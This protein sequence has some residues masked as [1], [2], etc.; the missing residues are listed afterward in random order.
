MFSTRCPL[1]QLR[2][3]AVTMTIFRAPGHCRCVDRG[4]RNVLVPKSALRLMQ[5]P[6]C[7]DA[8]AALVTARVKT[9]PGP[10]KT[11]SLLSD[12]RVNTAP[13]RV[14]NAPIRVQY[15]P[16]RVHNARAHSIV[17]ITARPTR[18]QGH[19][20]RSSRTPTTT[21]TTRASLRS[22]L[23][24]GTCPGVRRVSAPREG[25]L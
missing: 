6:D 19:G 12:C 22:S 14:N 20:H 23:R 2:S 11:S 21:A 10:K 3:P 8:A 16:I 17:D 7:P 18:G 24:S 1:H 4:Q 25:Q 13:I 15:A 5:V 9:R